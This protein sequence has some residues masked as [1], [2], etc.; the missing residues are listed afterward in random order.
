MG[1]Y[2]FA[3]I[4]FWIQDIVIRAHKG[5]H[6]P[7]LHGGIRFLES[8]TCLLDPAC[9]YI[10]T[11]A[12]VR[13]AIQNH[14]VPQKGACIL[15]S[16][17]DASGPDDP[18]TGL[19]VPPQLFLIETG[20]SLFSLYNSIHEKIHRFHAWDARLHEVVYQ[21]GGLQK[22]L[23]R[24]AEEIHGT[25]LLVN[26]GYKHVAAVYDPAVSDATADELRD[27]GYQSFDTIQAIRH[28]KNLR[29]HPDKSSVEY[30]SSISGNYTIVR[31]IRYH[32]D[33]MYRLCMILNGREP[34][35]CYADLAGIV[36]EYVAEYMFSNQGADY[37]RN[38]EFGMLA[39]DLIECRLTDPGE[40][41]E[42][43]KQIRLA[44]R[45]YYHLM[46]VSF[47]GTED[48]SM[49]PWNYVI[50]QLEV[51]FPFSNI[52]TYQGEILLVIRKMTRGSRL[53]VN[54]QGLMKILETY[55]GFACIGN[56]SEFL[57][58]L[59]PIYHQTHAALRLGT[60]M[61]PEQRIYYYEEYSIYQVIELAAQSARQTLGSRNLVHLCN[62]ES[63]ALFMYDK[64]NGTNLV[65]V[66]QTYLVHERNTTETAK[67]LFIH[68]NTMLYKIHKIEEVIGCSL[69]DP[70]L[71]ERLLFSCRV[72][73]YMTRYCK[74][75]ILV[76]KRSMAKNH[77]ENGEK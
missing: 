29:P 48:R 35:A 62:N 54:R 12:L 27:N 77:P 15:V 23:D 41:A 64:K 33:L 43:L 31:L 1:K 46:L 68:R 18:L 44:T 50:S 7:R 71:R 59:P 26:A 57:T 28:E 22:L 63:I 32:D 5:Q 52:T 11:P 17:R 65:Q 30:I 9:L 13:E 38:A 67:A 42:R 72:L 14:R 53:S 69:D 21:N 49:I 2:T 3:M 39:A 16:G 45:R 19:L 20:S 37:A 34:N 55:N 74:E 60:A 73:E 58:S 56:S 66:L 6:W 76:L 70:M 36:A 51:L 61:H 4:L 10:G 25:I 40:L 75:D 47:P 8:G 24:A